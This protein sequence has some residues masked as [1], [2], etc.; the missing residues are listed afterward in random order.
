MRTIGMAPAAFAVWLVAFS[1]LPASPS[2]AQ[3]AGGSETGQVVKPL[4]PPPPLPPPSVAGRWEL[5]V[6][7]SDPMPT[8]REPGEDGGGGHRGGGMGGRGGGMGGRGG[9]GGG[10][11]GGRGMGGDRSER[12]SG[13]GQEEMRQAMEAQRVLVIVQHDA[14]VT[15][16]D[17]GGR[18]V[19]IQPDGAKVKEEQAGKSIERTSKWDGRSLVTTV[20]LSSGT[21]VT[22]TYTKVAEGL[23]L[24]VATKIEGGRLPKPI[25]FKRVYDQALQ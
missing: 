18:V 17:E 2:V 23:Q 5:N 22:Q 10:G 3:Q 13:A 7:A 15:V 19:K 4:P 12:D 8:P 14:A 20:K 1:L 21:R 16:T 11:M 9:M 6:P 25:E 24:V